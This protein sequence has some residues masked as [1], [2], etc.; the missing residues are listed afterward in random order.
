MVKSSFS[1]DTVKNIL[2]NETSLL[3]E[4]SN[5]IY[6]Q[7]SASVKPSQNLIGTQIIR[8]ATEKHILKYT[9]QKT[10]LLQESSVDFETI[11]LPFLEKSQFS[12]DVCIYGFFIYL[13]SNY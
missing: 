10:F 2:T 6:S 12:V 13:N 8:P 5:D 11:T 4:F 7:H 3:K 1:E 9:Q